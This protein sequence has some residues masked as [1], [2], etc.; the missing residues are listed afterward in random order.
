MT[1]T[2]AT[3]QRTAKRTGEAAEAAFLAKATSLGFEVAKPW[4]DSSHF[5]FLVHTGPRCWRVQ[6]KSARHLT[7]RRY[8]VKASGERIRYTEELID[9]LVAYIVPVDAWYVIP[10]REVSGLAG[11]WFCPEPESRSRFERYREAWCLL[12]CPRD[13][14]RSGEIGVEERCGSTSGGRDCPFAG[15]RQ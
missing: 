9:F 4:G 11:L 15:K 3:K 1:A 12:A 10:I 7:K 14:Q 6:I 5:D 13:G 2:D 8:M